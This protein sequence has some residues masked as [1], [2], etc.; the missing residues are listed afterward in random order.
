MFKTVLVS[1]AIV[2]LTVPAAL[3]D[4]D[5]KDGKPLDLN[6]PPGLGRSS[7]RA[8]F[9]YN[10]GGSIDF[11]PTT[12]GST[13]GWGEWFVTTVHN[14]MGT[15]MTLVE[16]GFPCSGPATGAHGWMVWVGLEDLVS[17]SGGPETARYYG[18]FTPVDSDAASMP[19]TTYTYINLSAQAIDIPARGYFSIGYHNTGRGGQTAFNGVDS[20][21]WYGGA[22]DPDQGWARTAIIQVKANL[23]GATPVQPRTW[24]NIKQIYH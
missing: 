18:S 19:P 24:G 13:T 7:V 14:N 17:P 23:G 16:L 20:W 22:W 21:A 8:D 2:L 9:E 4:S 1:L 3:A 12:G 5:S 11:A 6:P 10:T 15:N